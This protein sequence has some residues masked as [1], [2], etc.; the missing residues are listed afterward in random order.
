MESEQGWSIPL[1]RINEGKRIYYRYSDSDYSIKNQ[2]IS[3]IDAIQLNETIQ[4]LNRFKGM[5]QFEWIE[6]MM[7]RLNTSFNLKSFNSSIVGFENNPYLKGLNFFSDLF[8]AIFYKK[9]IE[10][11]YKSFRQENPIVM[12]LSPYFLKQYN[13][14]WFLF[15]QNHELNCISNLAID[16][17]VSFSEN[18]K[19][20]IENTEIDFDEYFEDIIGVTMNENVPVSKIIIEI[21]A[22]RWPYIESK[23]IHG[24]QKIKEKKRDSV[25][26]ELKVQ[27]N[28]ELVTHLFSFGADIKIIE[29][30]VLSDLIQDR[31]KQ[32]LINYQ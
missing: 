9:S 5:P 29:P 20:Y 26:I 13:S 23:P 3:E 2:H 30:K 7:V 1:E 16:R 28:K 17:I 12:T 25:T 32:L 24:S 6:E 27:I 14:R 8:N 4:I 31:A 15:G 10:I 22:E 19:T 11:I 18:Y 21:N